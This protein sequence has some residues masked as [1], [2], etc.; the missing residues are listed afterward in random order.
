M[1]RRR[2][3]AARHR[4]AG[5]VRAR[6]EDRRARDQPHSTRT[7]CFVRGATR[8]DG[9]AGRGRDAE[10]AHDRGDPA[11]DARTTSR[12]PLLEVRGEV[13]MPLVRLPRAERAARRR[14]EEADAEPAQRGRR[15]AA[16]EGLR[17]ITASAAA[18]DL[19]LRHRR[20]RGRRRST[21]HWETLA[22]AA[23]ARLPH[24]PVRRARRVDRG[25][26]RALPRV[27]AAP[28]TSS[29]TRSTAS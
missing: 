13:Y 26:R 10:P 20:A 2:A 17:S 15:L 23:R 3:Q 19:G 12:R 9:V 1:G 21:S 28:R 8:G 5:R 18:L 22:V 27:G 25:G 7:A 11:A 4:R 24:E 16:A 6:A 29:T 14:R